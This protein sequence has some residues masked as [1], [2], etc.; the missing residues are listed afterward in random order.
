M[1]IGEGLDDG[2]YCFQ[3]SIPLENNNAK[4]VFN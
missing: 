1:K 2:D 3:N 4:Q